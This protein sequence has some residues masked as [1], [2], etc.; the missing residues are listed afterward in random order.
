MVL[1]VVWDGNGWIFGKG[2]VILH[3]S[4]EHLTVLIMQR[5]IQRFSVVQLFGQF[6]NLYVLYSPDVVQLLQNCAH[7]F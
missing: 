4:I 2:G 3:W 1:Y 7:Q 5:C 6:V